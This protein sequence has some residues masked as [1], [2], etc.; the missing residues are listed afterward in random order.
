[1]PAK[2]KRVSD[3]VMTRVSGAIEVLSTDRNAPRT[4]RQIEILSGL[5]HDA[6]ARAFRQDAHEPDN[7]YRLNEK[8]NQLIAPLGTGRRSP[9]AE[10]KHQDKQ[11]IAELKQQVGELNRQLDRY[12]MTLFAHYLADNPSTESDG[13]VP[14]RRQ[15]RHRY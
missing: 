7:P 11:R 10:E 13:A 4:K 5:G 15:K 8:F 14:M 1:M 9:A 2:R 6:V 3:D 12:A